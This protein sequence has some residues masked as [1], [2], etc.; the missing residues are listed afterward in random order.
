MNVHKIRS[1]TLMSLTNTDAENNNFCIQHPE[2]IPDSSPYD[3]RSI[4]KI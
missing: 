1:P 3:I 4:L 2:N